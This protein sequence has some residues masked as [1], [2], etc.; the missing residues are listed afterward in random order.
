MLKVVIDSSMCCLGF[1]CRAAGM[2]AKAI[3]GFGMLD[4]PLNTGYK[5]GIKKGLEKLVQRDGDSYYDST[6]IAKRLAKE[7]DNTKPMRSEKKIIA[8]GKKAGIAFSF[9]N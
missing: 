9:I 4:M 8:L 6:L 7:N 5:G 1:A 3:T 2:S